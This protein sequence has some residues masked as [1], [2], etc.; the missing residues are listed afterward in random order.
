MNWAT[1]T[2]LQNG[3]ALPNQRC[4]GV[5]RGVPGPIAAEAGTLGTQAERIATVSAAAAATANRSLT[6]GRRA[7]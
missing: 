7:G 1:S 6:T 4:A 5:P 2:G 3:F